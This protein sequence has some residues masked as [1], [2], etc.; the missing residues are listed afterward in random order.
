ME[1]AGEPVD[2]AAAISGGLTGAGGPI[3]AVFW[4][5]GD[6]SSGRNTGSARMGWS[7]DWRRLHLP[8]RT[9]SRRARSSE[10]RLQFIDAVGTRVAHQAIL[11]DENGG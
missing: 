8:Q 5:K 7:N 11:S 6:S 1:Q 9:S 4:V 10:P 2:T 3:E